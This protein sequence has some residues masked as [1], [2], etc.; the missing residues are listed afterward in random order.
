MTTAPLL[1][2]DGVSRRFG[3]LV[4]VRELDMTVTAGAIHGLIG[5]NGAG[6]STAFDLVSGLTRVSAGTVHF[7]GRDVTAAPAERRVAAGICRT[8]QTPRLFEAMTAL[9]TVMTGCHR[10][11]RCGFLASILSVRGK[12]ADEAAIRR[13]AHDL[14]ALV[15]LERAADTPVSQ[16]SYGPRRLVEIARAL[17]TGPKLLLLDEVASGLNPVETQFVA[18]LVRT[19]AADGL[20]VVLVEHDMRF[21]LGICERVTVLNFGTRIADGTPAEIV[22][23][24]AVIAAYLGEARPDAASRRDLRHAARAAAPQDLPS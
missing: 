2:L 23:D 7:D 6:K 8:F 17:A 5:P 18:D 22:A 24:P 4:A 15:G 14:L 9:E 16:L 1:R 11:S 3:G 19:L 13:R 20:T 21:I 12:A 10:T